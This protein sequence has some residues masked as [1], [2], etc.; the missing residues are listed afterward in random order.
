MPHRLRR[1]G[2]P[3]P[4]ILALA[5]ALIPAKAPAVGPICVA[6]SGAQ[7]GKIVQFRS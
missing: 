3:V 7:R 6:I 2:L 5:V 1:R 4:G